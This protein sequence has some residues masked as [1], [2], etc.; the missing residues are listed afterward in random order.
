MGSDEPQHEAGIV[1]AV[2]E[3]SAHRAH[4]GDAPGEVLGEHT[5]DEYQDVMDKTDP[6]PDPAHRARESDRIGAQC[7]GR[8][9][10]ARGLLGGDDDRF[11]HIESPGQPRGQAIR[12][13][14]E[15]GVTLGAVPASDACPARGL[16][17]IGAV[18]CQRTS[19]VRVIRTPLK[20]CIAPRLGPNVSL[21]GVPRRVSKLHRPWPG[22]VHPRG[23]TPLLQRGPET[24][25]A[26][27]P[28][29]SG[30]DVDASFG[31]SVVL[32][33]VWTRHGQ[34]RGTCPPL[35][36][37]RRSRAPILTA[38]TATIHRKGNFTGSRRFPD[39][40]VIPGNPSTE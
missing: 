36:H 22:G 39:C 15:G 4:L 18:A 11:E 17:R 27:L 28:G 26:L 13:Q 6:A 10:Q 9:A 33:N 3:P 30:E 23:P 35:A 37:T 12:Q 40:S 31:P 29:P 7:I 5:D 16:A 32:R 25:A 34:V 24:T 1:R 14:A 2:V 8:R 38:S 19:P 21:A 20:A